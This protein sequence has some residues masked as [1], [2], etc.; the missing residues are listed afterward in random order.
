[1]QH[2]TLKSAPTIH[3]EVQTADTPLLT[4]KDVAERLS[5]SA[6]LV[7]QLVESGKLSFH[8]IGT[9]R[10]TIRVSQ[11]DLESY[12]AASHIETQSQAPVV[13]RTKLKHIRL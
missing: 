2:N 7:Y 10:G 11:F 4:V 5:V 12:L 1:M 6:S 13:R 3:R 8:R 9:G